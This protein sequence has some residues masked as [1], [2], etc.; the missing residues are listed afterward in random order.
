LGGIQKG[1]EVRP[2]WYEGASALVIGLARSGRAACELLKRHGCAVVGSDSRSDAGFSR[3]LDDLRN[4]GV[5]VALG[6]QDET[7]LGGVD[8]VVL[9]PGVPPQ[10]PLIEAALRAGVPVISELEL[11]FHA[12]AAPIVAVT[13][14]NG[15]ST[16]VQML[17]EI[18]GAAGTEVAVAGNVGLALSE[19]AETVP[20]SGVLVV[21]VSSFQ[22]ERTPRFRP[23]VAVLLNVT[24]DHLD[25]HLGMEGYLG[26][27]LRI[28]AN[29][30]DPDVAV[31]NGDQPELA[32]AATSVPVTNRMTFSLHGPVESGVFADGGRVICRWKGADTVLFQ[33]D[34]LQVPGPHNLSNAMAAAAAGVAMDAP[35]GAV[36][37]GL[38]RFTGLE[39]RMEKAAV[40]DGVIFINDSKATNPD[41][42]RQA[43]LASPGKVVLIAGGR[44]KGM[45]FDELAELVARKTRGVFLIGEAA[46]RMREAWK[47][48]APAL[49]PSLADAVERAWS[50]AEEGDW[51]LLS[52]GCASFDM[53]EDFEDRGRKFK[54][55]VGALARRRGTVQK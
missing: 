8:L 25:R 21:E 37:D 53:F 5:A 34:A 52:P 46:G 50:A 47:S 15:K 17:G 23:H 10:L 33:A 49:S 51:V 40:L 1:R 28:F 35:A 9:S 11:A 41:S 3:S 45:S 39:H 43:L 48:S 54:E 20:T 7:L 26:M 55:I 36:S 19:V 4:S 12:A 22:L 44:D 14:T 38:C 2:P 18:F 31:L 42:L 16:C 29:Q 6:P 27:K 13:G 32:A 24:Q 30:R